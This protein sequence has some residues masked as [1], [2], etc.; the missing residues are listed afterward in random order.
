MPEIQPDRFDLLVAKSQVMDL[1][2]QT[3]KHAFFKLA[4]KAMSA[5]LGVSDDELFHLLTKREDEMTTV[6]A[7]GLAVPHVI[8]DGQEKF[9]VLLARCKKGI[10]FSSSQPLVYA[11][12][13]LIGSRDKRNFHLQALSAIARIFLEPG[14]EKKWM[15]AKGKQALK[16][17][18]IRA[19]RQRNT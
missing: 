3:D 16:Q 5:S 6:L 13:V 9:S 12:F 8:I 14:F 19:D 4:A 2:E 10:A 15:R 11:A 1:K 18:I 17:M 7:P